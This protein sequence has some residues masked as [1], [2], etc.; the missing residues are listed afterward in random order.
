MQAAPV[1]PSKARGAQPHCK[2]KYQ[3]STQHILLINKYDA[4]IE[5]KT[6]HCHL[7]VADEVSKER[8]HYLHSGS[9]DEPPFRGSIALTQQNMEE[10][11]P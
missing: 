1:I 8:N 11:Q 4:R 3:I 6:L 9:G 10:R 2:Y 7:Q 5:L